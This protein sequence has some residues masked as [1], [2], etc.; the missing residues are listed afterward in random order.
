MC[1]PPQEVTSTSVCKNANETK[2]LT[3]VQ[4]REQSNADSNLLLIIKGKV[5]DVTNFQFVHPGGHLTL[6]ALCGKDATESFFANHA[7]EIAKR[8]KAKEIATLVEGDCVDEITSAYRRL[9]LHME[10]AGLF[11]TDYTYYYKLSA[12]IFAMFAL[13]VYMVLNSTDLYVHC[14]AGVLLGMVWQQAA[15]IGHDL[16]HNGITKNRSVDSALGL[17]FGNFFT[18]FSIGWWKRSHNVHHIVTNSIEHD[19]DI[20]HLPI[21]A[22]TPKFLESKIFSTWFNNYLALNNV[23]HVLIKYQHWLYY[24]VMA[25]AR[26]NLYVQSLLHACG[27]GVYSTGEYMWHRNAQIWTLVGFHVW[28]IALTIQLPTALSRVMFYVLAHNVAG[29]LHVQITLSHFS[30]PTYNG[31]TYD[32][33]ANGFIQTQLKTSLDIDCPEWLDWF[34]GG[35]QFQTVHHVWPRIP[36]HNLRKVQKLLISFCEEKHLKY[37]RMAFYDANVSVLS[38]LKETSKATKS[39]NE[40]FADSFNLIG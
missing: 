17:F 1:V 24:P 8:L 23:A 29:V 15:F 10:K 6:R 2:L 12:R 9:T 40:I 34:H 37:N 27:I 4:V 21:F 39:F 30:M 11:E 31:V 22:I 38:K 36:R 25:F 26:F 32:N 16:G 18:G 19:P 33:C 35:L 20:Q 5:Y 3:R 28:M 13:V 7:P 14:L